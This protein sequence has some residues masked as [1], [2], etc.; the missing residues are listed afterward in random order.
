V[1]Q[2]RRGPETL[3]E[4]KSKKT[5]TRSF[6]QC[7]ETS[8]T[9]LRQRVIGASKAKLAGWLQASPSG[10]YEEQPWR[11]TWESWPRSK[12]TLVPGATSS[13]LANSSKMEWA[14]P[15]EGKRVETCPAQLC[16]SP[17][18]TKALCPWDPAGN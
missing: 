13:T 17:K 10:I 11:S 5:K 4:H 16:H 14:I 3:Q 18:A 1:N 15:R 7:L 12:S 9:G 6:P 8:V 2:I